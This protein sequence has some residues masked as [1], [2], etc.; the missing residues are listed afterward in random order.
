MR[1][2]MN[3]EKLIRMI[4]LLLIII[5]MGC[6]Q[7]NNTTGGLGE[8]VFVF[9]AGMDMD[10]IQSLID[11]IFTWQS[12][13]GSEFTT[14]RFALLFKPGEYDLD[15]RVGYYMQVAGL[16][17]SPED[18]LI[19]G[20]VRSNSRRSGGGHVLTNFW[21]A[22]EN[23]TVIPASDSTNVWGVSQAAP[24]RRVYIKGN[25]QLHDNGYSSGGFL[26]DSKIDGMVLFGSQQQ[27]FSRNSQWKGCSGGAWNILSMGVSGA[28][29]SNWPEGP[30]TS[31]NEVPVSREKPYLVFVNEELRLRIPKSRINSSNVSWSNGHTDEKE[32]SI[33][34]FY[35]ARPGTDDSES[36]NKA[37]KKGKN[38]LLT[39]GIYKLENCLEVI[40]P[41]TVIVG[42]GMPSLVPVYGNTAVRV[43]DVDGVILSGL[44]MDAGT[45]YSESLLEVGS[46]GSDGQHAGDPIWLFDIFCRVGGPD[47]GSVKSCVTINSNHVFVDHIWLWR[48][49]HGNG[50]GWDLNRS[51]SGL[52][53]NGNNV[54]VYGLFNEH[55]QEYQTVWNGEGGK[56]Y[57]Y[58]SEMPYDP[59]TVDAWKHGTT[60]GYASYKVEEH[61]QTHEAW[62]VGVYCVF[63]QAP[64]VVYTAIETPSGLEGNIHHK[65]TFWLNGNEDS[66]I[67]NI[68]NSKGESVHKDNRKATL[69]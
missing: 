38:I 11:T 67:E 54:S 61:V 25:L 7:N 36:I 60:G 39:P 3:A 40:R 5:Q 42:L 50:V 46:P 30:Y 48:A 10:E 64:V 32:I 49:D 63:Y 43:S 15:I 52:I 58:Q 9:D 19:R 55:H 35:I 24:M 66:I 6:S 53:V 45:I 17:E 26:A 62:C 65:F 2:V 27:W 1:H 8:S 20:A 47:Q 57:L 31:L 29:A 59:P 16:G 69:K 4:L 34:D 18:V 21:R 22:V 44:L 13:R 14:K 56:V 12:S 23:L 28:P 37:L 33:K 68:I 41:G 51:A